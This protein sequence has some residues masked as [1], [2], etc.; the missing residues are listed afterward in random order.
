MAKRT[1][2]LDL[3][4]IFIPLLLL[5]GFS[6]YYILINSQEY[7][8]QSTISKQAKT[9]SK[10]ASLKHNIM[11]EIACTAATNNSFDSTRKNC[12]KIRTQVDTLLKNDLRGAQ[13]ESLTHQLVALFA[14]HHINDETNSFSPSQTAETLKNI[15]YD[16]DTSRTMTIE[17]LIDGGYKH[18]II[19]P[20][21][22]NLHRLHTTQT[23]ATLLATRESLMQEKILIGYYLSY[24]KPIPDTQLQLW[25]THIAHSVFDP[26]QMDNATRNAFQ[27][28][29]KKFHIDDATN[30]IEEYR[31][32]I[33]SDYHKGNYSVA[34][35]TWSHA[36]DPQVTLL[37][38]LLNQTYQ[39]AV[40]TS[41]A[42]AKNLEFKINLSLLLL[43]VGLLSVLYLLYIYR[44]SRDEDAALERVI[45]GIDDLAAEIT[46]SSAD[47]LSFPENIND[48]KAV[49]GYLEKVLM[50]LKKKEKEASEANEANEAK[51]LFLA[52]MSHEI[53]TPLN[54]ILGFTQLLE[55]TPLNKEQQEYISIINSSSDNLLAIINDILDLSKM[56][57]NKMELETI[58]FDLVEKVESTAEILKAKSAEKEITLNVYCDP[59]LH[60]Y[61][62]GD[63]TKLAQ[64][65]TNLVG[66]AVKFTK[67]LG[68]VS[69]QVEPA[70]DASNQNDAIKFSVQDTGIGISEAAK[71]RI[72]EAFSQAD[73][74]TTRQYG[75][76]GLGLTISSKIVNLMGGELHVESTE[77]EGSTFSFVVPLA[78]DNS[79][80][81]PDNS[82]LLSEQT[83]GIL[84]PNDRGVEM[85]QFLGRYIQNLGGKARIYYYE[86]VSED[87]TP[88]ALPDT[89]VIFHRYASREGELD[90]FMHLDCPKILVTD[91]ALKSKAAH[92][93]E[94]FDAII[95]PPVTLDKVI[96]VT[97]KTPQTLTLPEKET[98]AQLQSDFG[99]FRILVAEDNPVNQQLIENILNRF[100]V[101]TTLVSDGKQ[102]VEMRKAYHYD[103][104]F[105]DIQMPILNG[106]GATQKILD[107]EK[108]HQLKHVPIIALTAN[109]LNG[110]EQKYLQSGMDAYL[111]K[112][113]RIEQLSTL[114]H[115]FLVTHN[116]AQTDQPIPS[117]PEKGKKEKFERK[118]P[119]ELLEV[120]PA[121]EAAVAPSP[122]T[123]SST[124]SETQSKG[125]PPKRSADILLYFT[126]SPITV[127]LYARVLKNFGYSLEIAADDYDFLAKAEDNNYS[128]V[129]F[130]GFSLRNDIGA[131]YAALKEIGQKAFVLATEMEDIKT[132]EVP[133]EDVLLLGADPSKLRSKLDTCII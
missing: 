25:D 106:T 22:E 1:K 95:T 40:D 118:L 62:M 123:K 84:L 121:H 105:M 74:S 44:R 70:D 39:T 61:R 4:V 27:A 3:L 35:D 89:M 127:K 69:V 60:R 29:T 99:G 55:T 64:V 13:D 43:G 120:A 66:N 41:K 87:I 124:A 76:T 9:A 36:S 20:I 56:S 58:A 130:G 71:Q 21:Q 126:S 67:P 19:Q 122:A 98:P 133:P 46:A 114:L 54:G 52:N 28:L 79:R 100:G 31:I 63:P 38:T 2:R 96:K 111:S 88:D 11:K 57:A 30:Q 109:A 97:Q 101:E 17:A 91:D 59:S 93:V 23:L 68:T 125:L 45:T 131:F 77:G 104:I 34:P 6:V 51:S 108:K 112:P 53:R 132:T 26:D 78:R 113:I 47:K 82:I 119:E 33:L 107:Y 81:T 103:L 48:K 80:E 128:C 72:F 10:L 42:S 8:K 116:E 37:N 117:K 90:Q 83:F 115:T 32:A 65:L 24:K 49:Y 12:E 14:P 15:R 129:I 18:K 92:I 102:A 110:D 7:L 16:I 73:I 50:L 5:M 94:Q 75:G 86:E 85:D